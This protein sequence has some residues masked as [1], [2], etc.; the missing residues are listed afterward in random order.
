MRIGLLIAGLLLAVFVI[1]QV[2]GRDDD[3][4]VATDGTT[5]TTPGDEAT[6]TTTAEQA[7][8]LYG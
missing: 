7:G 1:T 8:E 4:S 3:D 6:S 2:Q 5:T